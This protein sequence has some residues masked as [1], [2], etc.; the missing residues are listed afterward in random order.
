MRALFRRDATTDEIRE[1]LH[2]HVQMRTEEYA[3]QGLDARRRGR[4][5]CAGSAI[6]R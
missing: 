3:R 4:R 2:F 5:R 1:E 6:S